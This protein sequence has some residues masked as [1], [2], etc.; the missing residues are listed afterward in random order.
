LYLGTEALKIGY[1]GISQV[2]T[3]SRADWKTVQRGVKELKGE[4]VRVR[5]RIRQA[6]SGRKKATETDPSLRRD[7]E[8][9]L[10]PKGDPMSLI[11][12][13]THSL[14]HLVKA[15]S[16]AS[17]SQQEDSASRVAARAGLFAQGE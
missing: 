4:R 9:L 3:L 14:T 17:T 1:G 7:L 8:E 16:R 11:K 13:T 10:S 6:G 2:A 15:L 5:G 12:W